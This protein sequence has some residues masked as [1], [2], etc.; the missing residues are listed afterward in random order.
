MSDLR[1]EK[2]HN[3]DLATARTKAKAWL[4]EAKQEFDFEAT[5]HEG[6]DS[7]TVNITKSGVDGRAFLDSDKVVFE[8]DL[9]FLVKPF[10]GM[11]S[12]GIQEGLDK[13]FA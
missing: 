7:D 2:R 13:Y 12:S 8:A 3:F 1:I 11:I 6:L 10:K 9:N 5:Y 4:E